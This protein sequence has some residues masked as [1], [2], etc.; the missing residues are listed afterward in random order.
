MTTGIRTALILAAAVLLISSCATQKAGEGDRLPEPVPAAQDGTGGGEPAGDGTQAT[1]K[2]T[3]EG[4]SFVVSDELYWRTFEEIKAV[5]AE[6]DT[7]IREVHYGAWLGHLSREYIARTGSRE[8]LEQASRS[9]R[10]TSKKIVLGSLE[11]Y[12]VNVVVQSRLQATLDD[13][14]FVDETNVKALTQVGG[15]TYILYWLTREDGAW[16]IGVVQDR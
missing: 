8:F 14:Q 9:A 4:G 3:P 16:K 10:L 1:T 5:V 12:F 6:L 2:P 11:D 7:I 13:I 15:E